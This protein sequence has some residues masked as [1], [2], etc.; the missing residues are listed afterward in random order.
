MIWEVQSTA[1]FRAG[2]A[3]RE[4]SDGQSQEPRPSSCSL[5]K[6][7]RGGVSD[8]VGAEE[9]DTY[10]PAPKLPWWPARS[11]PVRWSSWSPHC[12]RSGPAAGMYRWASPVGT[13]HCC[14]HWLRGIGPGRR[15]LSWHGR[16][17]GKDASL[18]MRRKERH[19]D[20]VTADV[21]LRVPHAWTLTHS[22]HTASMKTHEYSD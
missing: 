10:L 21:A 11:G 6:E 3:Q 7:A 20:H 22:T 18:L 15:W 9:Q 2:L 17:P 14:I 19:R 13:A 8:R 16:S 4:H 1:I 5:G 12:T